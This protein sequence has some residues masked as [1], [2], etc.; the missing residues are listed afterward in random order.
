[1]LVAIQGGKVIGVSR[2]ISD[3]V[4]IHYLQDILIHPDYQKKGIGKKL[5]QKALN[6]FDKVR[7]HMILTDNE[8]RQK[9]FYESLG[10]KNLKDLTKIELNAYVKMIGIDLS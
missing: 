7:T 3:C 4:S 9:I 10:Y 5:L 8:E 6:Y 1:M 2:S